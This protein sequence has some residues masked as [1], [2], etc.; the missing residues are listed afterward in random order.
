M[1]TENVIV[2]DC[3]VYHGHGGFVVGSEMSGG[4]R[5]IWVKNCQ[6]IGTDIG[7]RFKSTRGRGG[8]VENIFIDGVY[9]ANMPGDAMTFDLYYAGANP[10]NNK[11]ERYKVDETTPSFRKISIQNVTILNAKR[12]AFINGLPEMPVQDIVIKNSNMS[13]KEGIYLNCVNRLTLDN[14]KI[15][16]EKTD[17]VTRIDDTQNITI[18]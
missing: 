3:R 9:M 1:P 5:N 15:T 17:P 8:V 16:A 2:K 13:G 11:A 18:R 6:F 10:G 14:V 4:V 7:L 12:C